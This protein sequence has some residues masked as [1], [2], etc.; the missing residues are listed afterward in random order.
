MEILDKNANFA[1][2]KSRRAIT[3]NSRKT[4]DKRGKCEIPKEFPPG[5]SGANYPRITRE[6]F[7][8]PRIMNYLEII[9]QMA[10]SGRAGRLPRIGREFMANLFSRG[11]L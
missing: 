10:G 9:R 1:S 7:S 5:N 11:G 4:R 8:D 6:L 2:V 3:D